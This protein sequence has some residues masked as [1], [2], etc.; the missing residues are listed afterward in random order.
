MGYNSTG[1]LE[2]N[3]WLI[4]NIYR[5][6]LHMVKSKLATIWEKESC[7]FNECQ[8][9]SLLLLTSWKLWGDIS[10]QRG[11]LKALYLEYR[12][13]FL[14]LLCFKEHCLPWN[15]FGLATDGF[16]DFALLRWHDVVIFLKG[17]TMKG[18]LPSLLEPWKHSLL[19]V[20][21][22]YLDQSFCSTVKPRISSG[23]LH[24]FGHR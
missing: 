4:P 18:I 16:Q 21:D 2:Q 8:F 5:I 12:Y 19:I 13:I 9:Q 1:K 17:D 7:I 23:A 11:E 3:K 22:L 14:L 24:R 10:P 15:L 20:S 6:L